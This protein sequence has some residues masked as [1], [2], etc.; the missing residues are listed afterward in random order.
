MQVKLRASFNQFL[1]HIVL[2]CV[3]LTSFLIWPDNH[4][5]IFKLT[6]WAVLF[7]ALFFFS[8]H[9]LQLK[10]WQY[11]FNLYE[12][13]SGKLNKQE[14]ILWRQPIVTV[15]A[16]FMF[17]EFESAERNNKRQLFIVWSDML[18]DEHYRQLCRLLVKFKAE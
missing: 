5:I 7:I 4:S 6:Y 15:F 1:S 18:S 10:L 9:L 8:K 14:F 3:C 11:D 17:I 16:C 2:M 12:D 13:G